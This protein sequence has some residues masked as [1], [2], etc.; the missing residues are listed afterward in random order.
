MTAAHESAS[1]SVIAGILAYL[2]DRRLQP[3]DRLPSERELA[4]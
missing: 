3:G 4:Q 2:R 1:G